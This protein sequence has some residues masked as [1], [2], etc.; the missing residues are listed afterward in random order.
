ME[1]NIYSTAYFLTCTLKKFYSQLCLRTK[2]RPLHY[3]LQHTLFLNSPSN[4]IHVAFVIL[5]TIP[6][7]FP[8]IKKRTEAKTGWPIHHSRCEV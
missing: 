5:S 1:T 8:K 7:Y 4:T 2:Q 6:V 3:Q